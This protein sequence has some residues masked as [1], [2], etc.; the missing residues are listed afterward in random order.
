[1]CLDMESE[2]P[3]ETCVED[4]TCVG[5]LPDQTIR[6]LSLLVAL[7]VIAGEFVGIQTQAARRR[8][9]SR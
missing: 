5:A 7:Q 4:S 9:S 1:M 2:E 3:V 6:C 8:T